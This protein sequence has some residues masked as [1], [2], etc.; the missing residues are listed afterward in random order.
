MPL[1]S[2]NGRH[3]FFAHIPKT[4]GSFIEERARA[5]GWSVQ[6]IVNGIKAEDLTFMP[7]TPQHFH[8]AIFEGILSI[9][10]DLEAFTIVRHPFNRFKSEYYWQ[11]KQSSSTADPNAW[12]TR[13]FKEYQENQNIYDNHIRPQRDFLPTSGDYKLFKLEEQGI[14][15]ALDFLGIQEDTRLMPRI[16]NI[17]R[18]KKKQAKKSTYLPHVEDVF[19]KRRAEIERFYAGDMEYFGYE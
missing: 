10:D 6:L 18:G 11:M 17:L 7:I 15:H 5:D 3:V 4:G 19:S 8:A 16:F 2:K 13:I 9:N 12:I 1:F 14:D